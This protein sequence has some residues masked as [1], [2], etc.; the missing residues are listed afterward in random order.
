MPTREKI[1][2]EI[3]RML[4]QINKVKFKE[5]GLANFIDTAP[6]RAIKKQRPEDH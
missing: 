5:V 6:R 1:K 4:T 3:R 2:Q